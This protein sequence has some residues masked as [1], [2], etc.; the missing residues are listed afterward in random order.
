MSDPSMLIVFVIAAVIVNLVT[1]GGIALVYFGDKHRVDPAPKSRAE[2][3]AAL[4]SPFGAEER[5][6]DR[7]A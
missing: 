3:R 6:L 4:Q 7:A 5:E 2:Q 1:Y